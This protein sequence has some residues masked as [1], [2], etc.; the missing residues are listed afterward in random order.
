[1]TTDMNPTIDRMLGLTADIAEELLLVKDAGGDTLPDGLKL[2]I[3][4]L[5]ELAATTGTPEPHDDEHASETEEVAK[6]EVAEMAEGA[7]AMEEEETIGYEAISETE[8]AF[9]PSCQSLE[10]Q[11]DATLQE[12]EDEAVPGDDP[13]V[14]DL[15]V[16]EAKVVENGPMDEPEPV[17]RLDPRALFQAFS[18]NDAFLFRREIFGGS[19]R[20]FLDSLDHIATLSDS[21][22]LR[23]Y[24]GGD[25]GLDLDQYP[26]R[27]FFQSLVVFF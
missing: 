16:E 14:E 24:L 11:I 5:A 8:P 9:E 20:R 21:R 26:G 6:E 10:D 13:V 1:M 2:K 27:E 25:L 23:E 3:I 4:S 22:A 19:K 7:Q 18:I 12:E 17:R 15:V